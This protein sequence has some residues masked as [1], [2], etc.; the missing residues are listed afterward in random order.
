M[1]A[2]KIIDVFIEWNPNS[3]E[4][5]RRKHGRWYGPNQELEL[6]LPE[7]IPSEYIDAC[8][9]YYFD[10]F[11]GEKTEA[12]GTKTFSHSAGDVLPLGDKNEISVTFT[13]APNSQPGLYDYLDSD[14]DNIYDIATDVD[15]KLLVKVVRVASSLEDKVDWTIP[16]TEWDYGEPLGPDFQAA[17]ARYLHREEDENNSFEELYVSSSPAPNAVVQG[18]YEYSFEISDVLDAGTHIL[19]VT[20]TPSNQ[21]FEGKYNDSISSVTKE[22]SVTVNPIAPV[23]QWD[24][25]QKSGGGS[26]GERFISA[27]EVVSEETPYITNS[28]SEY[29][30]EALSPVEGSVGQGDPVPGSWEYGPP[31]GT[32]IFKSTDISATFTPSDPN[33]SVVGESFSFLVPEKTETDLT[34]P[35]LFNGLVVSVTCNIGFGGDTSNCSFTVVDDPENGFIT[36]IPTAGTACYFRYRDFFFGG[37]LQRW[38]Y[39]ESTSGRKYNITLS[40]PSAFMDGVHIILSSYEGTAYHGDTNLVPWTGAQVPYQEGL[41][42]NVLNPLGYFENYTLGLLSGDDGDDTWL[43]D[44]TLIDEWGFGTW[45]DSGTNPQGFDAIKLLKT[46]EVISKGETP[47]GDKLFFGES[48]Y[49]LDLSELIEVVPEYYRVS[50]S[51]NVDLNSLVSDVCDLTQRDYIWEVTGETNDVCKDIGEAFVDQDNVVLKARL[52]DKSSP[53]DP[54]VIAQ[55]V[56]DAKEAG[57]LVNSSVGK[58]FQNESTQKIVLGAK[59][60]RYFLADQ[61]DM[62]P[63]YGQGSNGDY[64]LPR[65]LKTVGQGAYDME[66]E[67]I[68]YPSLFS[69]GPGDAEEYSASIFELRVALAGFASWCAYKWTQM[70]SLLLDGPDLGTKGIGKNAN[71]NKLQNVIGMTGGNFTGV[72]VGGIPPLLAFQNLLH[73][74]RHNRGQGLLSMAESGVLQDLFRGFAE[75]REINGTSPLFRGITDCAFNYFGKKFLIRLPEEPGGIENNLKVFKEEISQVP[76][77]SVSD[78]AWVEN[79]PINNSDYYDS[80][81]KLKAVA[82]YPHGST[83]DGK[84]GH[85]Y[86]SDIAQGMAYQELSFNDSISFVDLDGGGRSPYLL[87]D[88]GM[89]ASAFDDFTTN[90]HALSKFLLMNM[91]RHLGAAVSDLNNMQLGSFGANFMVPRPIVAPLGIGIPQE[92]ERYSWG[93]W[94][95]SNHL[96]GKLDFIYDGELAP[97]SFGSIDA[98]SELAQAQADTGI[99]TME[100]VENGSI[101][102]AEFPEYNIGDRLLATGP[103]VTNISIKIGISGMT[104][105]Y[106]FNTWTPDFG[107]LQKYN[108]SRVARIWRNKISAAKKRGGS[109]NM[110]SLQSGGGSEAGGAALITNGGGATV[111]ESVTSLS[112]EMGVIA[113]NTRTALDN[114]HTIL[115]VPTQSL[116]ASVGDDP[117]GGPKFANNFGGSVEQMWVGFSSQKNRDGHAALPHIQD[118]EIP[119]EI[120][121]VEEQDL[122]ATFNAYRSN[123]MGGQVASN[124]SI[125]PT[126]NDL[127]PYFNYSVYLNDDDFDFVVGDEEPVAQEEDPS[128]RYLQHMARDFEFIVHSNGGGMDVE[129]LPDTLNMFTILGIDPDEIPGEDDFKEN[130]NI[131]KIDEFR[132]P[133][134]RGPLV[135]SGWGYDVANNPVPSRQDEIRRFNK[136]LAVDRS[137]WKS[138]PVNLMWDKERKIWSGGLETLTGIVETDIESPDSPMRPTTFNLKVLRKVDDVKGEGALDYNDPPEII[139]CYNRDPSFSMTAGE[140][141]Y[142]TVMR[143]NYEWV[144]LSSGGDSVDLVA[145]ET[146]EPEEECPSDTQ[147]WWFSIDRTGSADSSDIGDPSSFPKNEDH[148]WAG[149][150]PRKPLAHLDYCHNKDVLPQILPTGKDAWRENTTVMYEGTSKDNVATNAGEGRNMQFWLMK[151]CYPKP[152]HACM[153]VSAIAATE[154]NQFDYFGI[155]DSQTH[156]SGKPNTPLDSELDPTLAYYFYFVKDWD[157]GDQSDQDQTN[158]LPPV[159]ALETFPTYT[160]EWD[161]IDSFFPAVPVII[162]D[163]MAPNEVAQAIMDAW[164]DA[165]WTNTFTMTRDCE[166][167]TICQNKEGLVGDQSNAGLAFGALQPVTTG[168]HPREGNFSGGEGF[169]A[170]L[171]GAANSAHMVDWVNISEDPDHFINGADNESWTAGGGAWAGPTDGVGTATGTIYEGGIN[172]DYSYPDS[173]RKDDFRDMVDILSD[174]SGYLGHH[175]YTTTALQNRIDGVDESGMP[176]LQDCNTVDRRCIT[177]DAVETQ[178]E[179]LARITQYPCGVTNVPGEVSVQMGGDG[180]WE[181]NTTGTEGGY[182]KIKDPMDAFFPRRLPEDLRGRRGVAMR[183]WD[184]IPNGP[185]NDDPTYDGNTVVCEDVEIIKVSI[186]ADGLNATLTIKGSLP[187]RAFGQ[188]VKLTVGD[189][190]YVVTDTDR[191]NHTLDIRID[192][193]PDPEIGAGS[194]CAGREPECYWMVIYMDMFDKIQLVHDVIIGTRTI[195]TLKKK[196]DVWNHCDF[197]PDIYEGEDCNFEDDD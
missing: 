154:I 55:Y 42:R 54:G 26:K 105:S 111:P 132:P 75:S 4:D 86:S 168:D 33:Y 117:N 88:T 48:Q 47:H 43:V 15:G 12:Q 93:P 67:V 190:T 147:I 36:D 194:L 173:I 197:D 164:R 21:P 163:D 192:G 189:T 121:A 20:F 7:G 60:T 62:I 63:I 104:T 126:S 118:P 28:Q 74:I 150:E 73:V 2:T 116:M 151:T 27:C 152:S 87:I 162:N 110:K 50:A 56:E 97:E 78:S 123:G 172:A 100:E 156:V 10:P 91:K 23:I 90:D 83:S 188:N 176:I 79:A 102:V 68:L 142:L 13:T 133:S 82:V 177:V 32:P 179:I 37:I 25:V 166:E 107:R 31:A 70:L 113:G 53:P 22:I 18:D 128:R 29:P 153:K 52:I 180:I 196:V 149:F 124:V 178:E 146:Q 9:V 145:F 8:K 81:G 139:K 122:G 181:E 127:D 30:V 49:S 161:D 160:T 103:Y 41:I 45:G 84:I 101:E 85:P 38:N 138:G 182:I 165:Y 17:Q 134:L 186:D 95:N 155:R 61:F 46:I 157:G 144:P 24:T 44:D 89:Q 6:V 39:S 98:M 174:M 71:W 114:H 185:C 159:P 170:R 14:G 99:A 136:S 195:T 183:V 148:G 184:Y 94:Y 169:D 58:E 106:R 5:L 92:S 76:S 3:E 191:A 96:N 158:D 66:Q 35:T 125:M 51:P 57:T 120:V 72:N 65:E 19:T 187:T 135:V 1:A 11:T 115:H 171:W 112:S 193:N 109:Q 40:S 130:E 34:V 16:Q 137:N 69:G 64:L 77:W 108:Q 140:N 80:T 59:A 129:A 167:I 141:S 143:I 131:N 119:D 175:D